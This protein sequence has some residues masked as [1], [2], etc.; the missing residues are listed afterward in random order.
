MAKIEV[1][2]KLSKKLQYEITRIKKDVA[3][4]RRY[5]AV[6]KKE[7]DKLIREN[8]KLGNNLKGITAE[9]K[10]LK[11]RVKTLLESCKPKKEIL[12]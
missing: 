7:N 11:L 8:I 2:I 6:L 10:E 9:N 1:E 12:V 4:V 5:N 3:N